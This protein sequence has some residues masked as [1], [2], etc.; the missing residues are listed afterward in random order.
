MPLKLGRQDTKQ[1][2]E[3]LRDDAQQVIALARECLELE[4]FKT[5]KERALKHRKTC[6]DAL[7]EYRENDP[8]K[9]AFEVRALLDAMIYSNQLLRDIEADAKMEEK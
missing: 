4:K 3:K 1:K 5:Y 2:R 8:I 6:M 9:Y 7:F